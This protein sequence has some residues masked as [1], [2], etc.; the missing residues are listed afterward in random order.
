RICLPDGRGTFTNQSSISDNSEALFSYS[1]NF[2]N[3][4]DPSSS[5]L[6]EPTHKYTAVG[7]VN[8][9]LKITTKDACVDSLTKTMNT[10]YP[11]PKAS[12]SA[13]PMEVCVG[14]TIQF[15]DL[16]DLI[17][18]GNTAIW[19]W[20][21][22]GGTSSTVQNPLKRF[23][24]SGTFTI[25][26]FFYNVNGCVSDTVSKN[27]TVHPYPKLT[28][29][30]K[31]NVLEGNSYKI[32]PKY[33]YGTNLTYQWTPPTYLNNDVDSTPVT[34]P[35]AD[36]R[37]RLFLTG[38]GGCTV[39]DTIFIKVLFA[40][41]APNAFSPN[42][43]G[44]NDRWRIKYLESYPGATVEVF[45]RY[46]QSVFS[47]EGYDVDWDGTVNGKALPIGTYYYVINPKNGRKIV[48][49][50]VTIIR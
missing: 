31:V 35:L 36:I 43:D 38:I 45:N 49:G 6:R 21:L 20:D 48:T 23:A 14:D 10:I 28:L 26:Y 13:T 44:I 7:P 4:N 24:D 3:P 11:W 30:S 8:V 34:T 27:V 15:K 32:V 16:G 12:F 22:S 25:K 19:N 39:S 41:I 46:G 9:Q 5:T 42:G 47:S 37:Y 33:K 18:S 50:S 17:N 2:G 29:I 1:W 40:P